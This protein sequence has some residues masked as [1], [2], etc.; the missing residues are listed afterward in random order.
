MNPDVKARWINALRSGAY[1]QGFGLLSYIDSEGTAR[2]CAL[3]VLCEL[4]YREGVVTKETYPYEEGVFSYEGQHETLPKAVQQ[5]AGLNSN[6]PEIAGGDITGLNDDNAYTLPEI[7]LL[8]NE[9]L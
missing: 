4:A 5:W 7:A 6:N 2:Y 1:P 3:G 9:Y 8:I